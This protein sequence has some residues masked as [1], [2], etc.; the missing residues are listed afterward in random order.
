MQ[1]K[2]SWRLWVLALV[3][4]AHALALDWLSR[5]ARVAEREDEAIQVDFIAA[6]IE[7]PAIVIRPPP[8]RARNPPPAQPSSN[9]ALRLEPPASVAP[10]PPER[11]QLYG[12]DGRLRLPDNVMDEV[13]RQFGEQRSFSYQVPHL[14]DASKMFYRPKALSYES[15]RFDKYW[16]PDQ[17][18]L[19]E[20]LTRAVERTTK[21]IR[22]PVPGNPK[23]TLVCRVS[24]LALGGGC[25]IEVNGS[26]YTGPK[27]DPNTLNPEEDRQCQAW[28]DKIIGARTQD[29]WRATRKLYE[30]ECR[31]PLE[32]TQR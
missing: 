26:D 20:L 29:E 6:P 12:L 1:V 5:S 14:D 31:K 18:L 10:S 3:L 21:E 17:D 7:A 19:T 4:L 11:L 13:D 23:E 32:R 8:K 15:T 2:F 27:D 22:I 30:Q 24:L 16:R 9:N 25:G 28:W